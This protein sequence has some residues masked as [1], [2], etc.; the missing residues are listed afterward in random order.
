M[1]NEISIGQPIGLTLYAIVLDGSSNV[2]NTLTA[3]FETRAAANWPQY[4]I[5]LTD[6]S[7]PTGIYTANFPSLVAGTYE[8]DLTSSSKSLLQAAAGVSSGTSYAYAFVTGAPVAA[9]S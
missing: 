1:A 6:T 9:E 3:A 2:W 7:P 5:P 8:V 4:A